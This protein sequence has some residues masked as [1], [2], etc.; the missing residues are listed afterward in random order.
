MQ[1]ITS[2]AELKTL[3]RSIN[4]SM[5]VG[6]VPTMGNLHAGH[7]SLLQRAKAENDITFLTIFINPTQFNN[8]MDL[9]NYPKTL[10]ADLQIARNEGIDFV[11]LPNIDD[12]YPDNFHFQIHEMAMSTLLEGEHR[13]GHFTGVMTIVMKLFQLIKPT[14]AYFGEKDWQQ[15]MLVKAMVEAFFLDIAIIPCPTIRDADGLPLS[16]RN[17]LLSPEQKQQARFFPKYFHSALPCAIIQEKLMQAGFVVEYI[18]EY[19]KRRFAAV[20]LGQV[21]LI[22]NIAV[23]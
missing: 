22:D 17:N 12:M 3:R 9:K 19:N 13:P 15:L 8:P 2:V 18:Q 6:I 5:Q 20:K 21:R 16:S 10:A 1:L 4:A 7:L 23:N 14:R 11:F